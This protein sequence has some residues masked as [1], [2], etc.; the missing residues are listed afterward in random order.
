MTKFLLLAF[1][2]SALAHTVP[3][4]YVLKSFGNKKPRTFD[5]ILEETELD[6]NELTSYACTSMDPGALFTDYNHGENSN[7]DSL[8]I[9]SKYISTVSETNQ[10]IVTDKRIKKKKV[11]FTSFEKQVLKSLRFIA[12]TQVGK[13]LLDRIKHSPFPI[14]I[15]KGGNRFLP[16][17]EGGKKAH[18]LNEAMMI[19]N[20]DMKSPFVEGLHM[21]KIG[22]GGIVTWD[23]S[24]DYAHLS[25]TLAHELYHAYDS[26]RGMLD[27][28]F[29]DSSDIEFTQVNEARAVYFANMM[30]KELGMQYRAHYGRQTSGPDLL[31]DAGE[32]FFM[33]NPCISSL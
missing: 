33:P 1:S 9:V 25:I 12:K 3:Y 31:D 4:S 28:R 19:P 32:P 23:P 17:R 5:Q 26:V 21:K 16:T 30:R 2:F 8:K 13:E 27:L 14:Y 20:L 29:I 22:V 24:T 11:K 15:K 10:L 6:I 18:G 7:G